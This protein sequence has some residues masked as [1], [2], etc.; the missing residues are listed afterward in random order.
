MGGRVNVPGA[1]E[2]LIA[3][4]GARLDALSG[5]ELDEVARLVEE[6]TAAGVGRDVD[7]LHFACALLFFGGRVED[8]LVVWRAKRSS[9]DDALYLDLQLALGAGRDEVL[10]YCSNLA[11][12]AALATEI[13][14]RLEAGDV[15]LIEFDPRD[16]GDWLRG[17]FGL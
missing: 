17:Y 14:R 11:A 15:D 12:G 6:D 7:F 13:R 10:R 5:A 8:A 9:F 2:S 3:R 4:F 16:Y 1:T